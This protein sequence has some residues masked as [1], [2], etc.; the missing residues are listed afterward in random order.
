MRTLI[1]LLAF[2][3][4]TSP[5]QAATQKAYFAGGCFWCMESEFQTTKG[6]TDVVSGY[7]TRAKA[8]DAETVEVTYDPAI[9]S[10]DAL[11]SIYWSNIDPT[12][13]GGQ[14]Y[15]RGDHYKTVIF[16]QNETE[17]AAASAS[18]AKAEKK[19]GAQAIATVIE[20]FAT[21]KVADAGH[22]DFF[23]KNPDHY[24]AY[25]KGSGRKEKI[26]KVWQ[27]KP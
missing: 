17:R 27:N 21:F 15:D 22:Q 23:L 1:A 14:F 7:A 24:Q 8:G 10:Y 12:D 11:L 25:V 18:K 26:K 16:V 4:F 2:L 9:V 19:L 13:A 5:A 3:I 20:P 6:V